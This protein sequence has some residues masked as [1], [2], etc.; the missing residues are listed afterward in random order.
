MKKWWAALIVVAILGST[1]QAISAES[2]VLYDPLTGAVLYEKQADSLMLFASTTK[3]MTAAVALDQYDPDM[4]VKILPE[5][6]GIEGSSMYLV[7]GETVTVRELLYGL[8]L[9][10]GNDAA[11]AL[12]GLYNGNVADFVTLMNAKAIEIGATATF[13]ENPNGLDGQNH[14]TTAR[15]LAKIA[16]YAMENPEFQKIV[17]TQSTKIGE[18]YFTNHN[19]LLSMQPGAVGVKTGFTKAAGRCLVSAVDKNGRLYVAV[20]L[21]A[22]DDWNDHRWMYA[23]YAQD[24][25]S[26]LVLA[27]DYTQTIPIIGGV[28]S[29][30]TVQ[31]EREV[32]LSLCPGEQTRVEVWGSRFV[33][34]GAQKGSQYGVANIYLGEK[35]VD[36]VPLV[37]T[38]AVAAT[39]QKGSIWKTIIEKIQR[40]FKKS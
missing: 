5:W 23:N 10:S 18:R 9:S 26:T 12:A 24:A 15:D 32:R 19:R 3:I 30:V 22:P 35:I 37:Y 11:V 17:G 1:C 6:T 40:S 13:F 14:K 29:T 27:G 4:Q 39:P 8:L 33:Y 25:Q 7:P 34:G 31:P 21:K 38:Q 16:A 20:T 2:A 28:A 36:T